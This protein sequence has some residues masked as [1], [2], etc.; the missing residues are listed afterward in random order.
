MVR[1]RI[2][3]DNV[4]VLALGLGPHQVAPHLEVE[5]VFPLNLVQLWTYPPP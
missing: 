3:V 2:R 1:V 5:V 4:I